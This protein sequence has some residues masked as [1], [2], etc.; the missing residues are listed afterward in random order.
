[1]AVADNYEAT[2]QLA[3]TSLSREL[4]GATSSVGVD[5]ISSRDAADRAA[6][7]ESPEEALSLLQRADRGGDRVL[8]RAIASHATDEAS[9][10][11][12]GFS[13][14]PVLDAF[15]SSYGSGADL[16]SNKLTQLL[17]LRR[18]GDATTSLSTAAVFYTPRP[19]EIQRM[20]QGELDAAGDPSGRS[21]FPPPATDRIGA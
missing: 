11:I 19:S 7:V 5:A 12:T 10:P 16:I 14:L 17:D 2:N 3:A 1:Q 6:A 9:D 18:P 4:F 13:W 15:A 21:A 20:T 8:V